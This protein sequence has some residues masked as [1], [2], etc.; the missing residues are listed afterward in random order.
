[1]SSYKLKEILFIIYDWLPKNVRRFIS[2]VIESAF[3]FIKRIF[4]I[5]SQIRLPIYIL[6]GKDKCS[7][8][9]LIILF[10]GRKREVPYFS[11]MLYLEEPI[12]NNLGKIFIWN[13]KSLLN[14]NLPKAD[15]ILIGI[16]K[17][18]SK[19][20]SQNGFII[21]PGRVIFALDL[22][23]ELSEI[24][25]LSKN[26]S[27]SRNIK[28]VKDH[29]YS[30]E[31]TKDPAIF[32]YFYH[33]MYLPYVIKRFGKLT[34]LT[35]FYYM[36]RIFDR[37]QL[38]LVK[39]GNEYVSGNVIWIHN[40]T[41]FSAYNGIKNGK[42]KYLKEG[43]LAASYYFTILWAKERG[44]RW[45]DF[46]SNR[47]FLNDGIFY[48]KKKWGMIIKKSKKHN[49]CF[50]MKILNLN[51]GVLNFLVKN[52]FIFMDKNKFK[53]FILTQHK[54]PLTLKELKYLFKINHIPGVDCLVIICSQG[55][56]QQAKIFAN[57]ISPQ[58]LNLIGMNPKIFLKKFSH[59]LSLEKQNNA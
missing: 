51:E 45:L 39:K 15:L 17:L 8:N 22:S 21:I 41:V 38:L 56:T 20:L 32:R 13:I 29:K 34:I 53:G 57:S 26:K 47:P 48:H 16:D 43:A 59:I 10:F 11:D 18:F 42:I 3:F 58:R 25:K 7:N 1:M 23:K 19:F 49:I 2:P 44:Y 30:Y 50:G 27:L 40:K 46:G 6:Q 14:L 37:G 54:H 52:P 33:K 31:I 4:L 9:N 35:S 36:K 5:A 28:R 55:F 24:W 12:K